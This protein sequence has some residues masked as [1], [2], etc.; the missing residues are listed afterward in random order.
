MSIKCGKSAGEDDIIPEVLKYVQI[1]EIML[2]IINKSF[3]NCEQPDLWNISNIIR[4]P[5]SGNLTITDNYQGISLTSIMAKTYNRMLLN[6]IRP[7]LDPLL[8]NNQNV[9]RQERTTVGHILAIR[10]ILEGVKNKNVHVVFTFIDFKKAFDSVHRGKMIKILRSYGI[11]DKIINVIEASY[12]STRAKIYSPDGVTEEFDIVKGVLQGDTQSLY[13]FVIILDHAL[14]KAIKGREE[15]LGFT[16]VPRRS[17]RVH[18]IVLTDLDFADDIALISDSVRQASELLQRVESECSKVGLL[19]NYNKTK[20]MAF[21]TL[22]PII[23]K[24][25][26]GQILD[27]EK[28][29]KYLGSWINS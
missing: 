3:A 19:I 7:I 18:P 6:R 1:N 8:R 28:D 23:L 17:R 14:R 25:A 4:I 29:F 21:N 10:R 12:A 22:D 27:V 16:I 13:L 24:T 5:K 2:D 20:V 26:D 11:P 9:F 15:E